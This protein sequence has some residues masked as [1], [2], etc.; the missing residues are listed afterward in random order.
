M[1][2]TDAFY[3]KYRSKRFSDIIGQDH[4]VQTL[5][6]AIT[7]GRL[8]HAY[9][10][11][12]PRGTGKTSTARILAKTLNC[13]SPLSQTDPCLTCDICKKI[14]GNHSMDV[15]ELDAASHTSVDYI[16]E[17]NDQVHFQPIECRYK[18]YIIDEAHMLSTGAFN[19]LLKTIEEPP[20]NVCFVLATTEAH[21]IPKTIQSRCQQLNFS[22]ISLDN[23]TQ[24][25]SHIVTEEGLTIP[26][27]AIRMIANH[28]DGCM[29]DG[30]TLLDQVVASHG[31]TLTDTHIQETIGTPTMSILIQ[32]LSQ[33]NASPGTVMST[34]DD[35]FN[36]GL[37]PSAFVSDW[38]SLLKL[39]I[40]TKEGIE[41]TTLTPDQTHN[42]RTTVATV[43][44]TQLN[45][46]LIEFGQL[47]RDIRG[48]VH[49][50]LAIQIR[51]LAVRDSD[52][53]PKPE[54]K[55]EP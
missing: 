12:G 19:A 24:Q 17:L 47:S 53:T 14:T 29:R 35:L 44:A 21:K 40:M 37:N 30:I 32:L 13:R 50:E 41:T 2:N 6:N 5:S 28:A 54:P 20:P 3:R 42:L 51:F 1:K 9:I 46:Y 23:I 45:R 15:V 27:H 48:F 34:L 55:L 39:S 49:P 10:L 22:R 18:L 7:H 31:N 38:L 36:T 4:I 43:S 16:R 33:L 8:A 25:L 11:S 52:P 26:D